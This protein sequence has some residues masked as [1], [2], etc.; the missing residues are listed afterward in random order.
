M[1]SAILTT[2]PFRPLRWVGPFLDKELRVTSRRRRNYVMRFA[3][4]AVLAAFVA[5][6]WAGTVRIEGS[7]AVQKSRMAAA[8]KTIVSAVVIFQFLATQAAAIVMLSTAVSDEVYH[9]TL[10]LLMTTPVTGR[11]IVLG[12]LFSR[13][14][15]LLQLLAMSL[16]LLAVVR[17]FGGVPAGYVISSFCISLTAVLFAGSVS[18]FFSIHDLRAYVVI[19]KT[20]FILAFLFL[21]VPIL[22]AALRGPVILSY[23]I[24]GS[25]FSSTVFG[26]V[27]TAVLIHVNPIAVM[28]L[29][30]QHMLTPGAAGTLLNLSWPAHCAVMLVL[31]AGVLALCT[32]RVRET[33]L[34]QARGVVEFKPLR[35][36]LRP[37][38]GVPRPTMEADEVPAGPIKTVV[39]SPVLWRELRAPAI[40]GVDNTNS[41]I[42]FA[43]AIVA[44]LLTYLNC[45]DKRCLDSEVTQSLYVL[46]F[47]VA[48]ALLTLVRAATS[49]TVEKESR[50]WPLVLA[51]PLSGRR[52]LLDKALAIWR[53]S[54]P[55]WLFAVC[56]VVLFIGVG[57]IHP[58]AIVHVLLVLAWLAVFLTGAGLYF[59]SLLR[60]ST[61]AVVAN[62]ALAAVLWFV[63]PSLL[64]VVA[65]ML[66]SDAVLFL[67]AAVNP[68]LQVMVTIS[69]AAGPQNAIVFLEDLTYE[70]PGGVLGFWDTTWLLTLCASAYIA[71]GVLLAWLAERRFRRHIF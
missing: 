58:G 65:A 25:P 24:N 21:G 43:C 45:M 35:R 2:L 52:I 54:A 13:L 14:L 48:G 67:P 47:V 3:Y 41:R 53:R 11:Q 23:W 38:A 6:V 18:L 46:V 36:R 68:A 7:A 22:A 26:P 28:G 69:G 37:T 27:A 55:V 56:H 12:K 70:W 20:A 40:Q 49:I 9:R 62:L 33:A 71:A 57:H 16:P 44:V 15:Q 42:G 30:T 4:M 10:G 61:S 29:N 34:R 64:A 17:I 31:V 19:I 63:V 39:G 50:T 8:G 66:R 51:T 5:I 32:W 59:S 60:R 1:A